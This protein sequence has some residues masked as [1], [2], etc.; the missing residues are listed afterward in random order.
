VTRHLLTLIWNRRRTNL[1][2]MG[3]IL[4][5]FLVL[6]GVA[7]LGLQHLANY[8]GPV[9]YAWQDVW[10]IAMTTDASVLETS[11][12]ARRET[13]RRLLM[14]MEELPEV[15]A[16]AGTFMTPYDKGGWTSMYSA[17]GREYRYGMNS[18]TDEF[19]EVMGLEMLQGRWFSAA[20]DGAAFRP[21][22][23]NER[24]ALGVFGGGDVVGRSVP[25]DDDHQGRPRREMRVVGV[26]R[27][28]RQRGEFSAPEEFLF[29]RTRLED[30]QGGRL[31]PRLIIRVRPGTG[32]AFEERLVR[33]LQEV[34]RDWSFKVERLDELRA[35]NHREHLAPLIA[36]GTVAGFLLLMVALGLTGV[37]WQNVTQRTREIGLRRAKGATAVRIHRQVLGEV[38]VMTSLA[39]AAGVLIVVQLPLLDLLGFMGRGVFAASLAVSALALYVLTVLCGFYPARLATRVQPAEA[40]HY[41]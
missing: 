7:T 18:V 27:E 37:L 14:A 40:L 23:I 26:V 13:L 41:E 19:R 21:V 24:F 25:Q 33:R 4:C 36:V 3:E 2:V 15:A 35:A 34:A 17:G 22:V 30:P 16:A 38:V 8:R 29:H 28:F 10:R 32:G 39:L 31:P 1:L 6:F 9:G 20:D 11:S 5:S 12:A